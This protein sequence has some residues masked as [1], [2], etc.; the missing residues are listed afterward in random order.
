MSNVR[1]MRTTLFALAVVLTSISA[2]ADPS[3]VGK[4]RSERE[5]TIAF[6]RDRA[7]LEDKTLLFIE[8]MMGR[9]TLTFTPRRIASEMPDWQSEDA[10]GNKSNLVGFKET[11]S[12]KLLG[13][14]RT[15]VAI[16]SVE[17][18]T[19]RHAI[20]IYNFDNENTMWVYLG[21]A[22]FPEMN[23]REY[24]VRVK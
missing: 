8:Q 4:W 11:H 18:V 19:G 16:A 15:Q 6:A 22:P 20:T 9:M 17:P 1:P 14:T 2:R 12:Y 7:K 10:A 23:I 13:S 21:G 5:L 24:F 3:L